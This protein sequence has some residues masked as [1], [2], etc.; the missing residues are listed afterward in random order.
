MTRW[1]IAVLYNLDR[2]LASL[3]GAPPQETIS[4]EAARA[5][6]HGTWWGR[7]LCWGF[8]RLDP[9]HCTHARTHADQLN[10]VD[11]GREG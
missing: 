9:G 10:R 11:D 8:N 2:A 7:W 4:S 1:L 3:F 6:Q 5:Q